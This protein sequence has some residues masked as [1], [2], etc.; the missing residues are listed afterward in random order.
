MT[1]R[2]HDPNLKPQIDC[3]F[4]NPAGRPKS[5]ML[6]PA[7][8]VMYPTKLSDLPKRRP[9]PKPPSQ[10]Q[11]RVHRLRKH[12]GAE[13][14]RARAQQVQLHLALDEAKPRRRSKKR[15]FTVA[16]AGGHPEVQSSNR[17]GN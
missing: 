4:C 10:H 7:V 2:I 9:A 13:A 15:E 8:V 12:L 3:R 11:L 14:P 1:C 17:R 6:L 5:K 16:S